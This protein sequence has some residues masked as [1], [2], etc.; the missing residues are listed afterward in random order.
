MDGRL[1][2]GE[3]LD[4][5][6]GRCDVDEDEKPRCVGVTTRGRAVGGRAPAGLKP[7]GVG[8]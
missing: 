7:R 8:D 4:R 6:R 5:V 2:V 3:G 1:G